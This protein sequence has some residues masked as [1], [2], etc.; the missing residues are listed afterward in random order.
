[1][2]TIAGM[3][4]A[5][6]LRYE[7]GEIARPGGHELRQPVP[8]PR[9]PDAPPRSSGGGEVHHP[10]QP[11]GRGP[12]RRGQRFGYPSRRLPR[13]A[14]GPDRSHPPTSAPSR[15]CTTTRMP[16][17][18]WR[19]SA[20][21]RRRRG[22]GPW[23]RATCLE[24]D[25]TFQALAPQAPPGLAWD[26]PSRTERGVALTVHVT[27]PSEATT[28]TFFASRSAA[29]ETGTVIAQ[30][31]SAASGT[32]STA[33]DTSGDARRDLLPLRQG[34][35]RDE[36]ARVGLLRLH[37]GGGR[38]RADPAHEPHRDPRGRRGPPGVDALHR[39]RCGGVRRLVHR[40]DG[41]SGDE[42]HSARATDER[43]P[44]SGDRPQ[45]ELPFL[46]RRV[47]P[48]RAIQLGVRKR[49]RCQ[50]IPPPRFLPWQ[51]P[52]TRSASR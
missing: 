18:G 14:P 17:R 40:R 45:Q 19:S 24:S 36:P 5:V 30:R 32:V 6:A 2:V 21:S 11:G 1:M 31:L 46:R 41:S 7:D 15:A 42:V 8:D 13:H 12:L 35:R 51:R 4:V 33:W 50:R 3:S 38:G 29:G 43:R 47:R 48:G 23:A 52:A 22:G 10:R 34:R 49:R 27:P 20:S 28:V 44:G 37:R 39:L 9:E 26:A 16:R 25:A